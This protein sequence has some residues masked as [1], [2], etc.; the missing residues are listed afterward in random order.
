MRLVSCRGIVP[1]FC[2]NFYSVCFRNEVPA[3]TL[4]A[5]QVKALA[6]Q[7]ERGGSLTTAEI[8]GVIACLPQ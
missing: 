5:W 8:V 6:V 3:V 1:S 2:A 7:A 4:P